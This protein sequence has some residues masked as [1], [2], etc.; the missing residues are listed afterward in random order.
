MILS[1]T[2]QNQKNKMECK[3]KK[4]NSVSKPNMVESAKTNHQVSL[5]LKKRQESD[6]P[7]NPD[8][9]KKKTA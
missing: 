8:M 4:A 6:D 9:K 5:I 1:K 3:A 2:L 7:A